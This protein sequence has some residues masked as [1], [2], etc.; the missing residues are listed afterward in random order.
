MNDF[1][2]SQMV[3]SKT[4]NRTAMWLFSDVGTVSQKVRSGNE[5]YIEKNNARPALHTVFSTTHLGHLIT[6]LV[7]K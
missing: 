1:R 7:P 4:N 2:V 6:Q 5:P 3:I